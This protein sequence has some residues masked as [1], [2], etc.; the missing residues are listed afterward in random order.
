MRSPKVQKQPEAIKRSNHGVQQHISQ[1]H[2]FYAAASKALSALRS[3]HYRSCALQTQEKQALRPWYERLSKHCYA[4][5]TRWCLTPSTM[6][7][8][9]ILQAMGALDQLSFYPD[10]TLVTSLDVSAACLKAINASIACDPYIYQMAAADNYY[11]LDN[12]TI[13]QSIYNSR[14]GARLSQY[15]SSIATTCAPDP[16]PWD[17]VPATY[18]LNFV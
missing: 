9:F 16:M 10:N 11:T 12:A 3:S 8:I 13:Q 6:L 7:A 18:L 4:L 15:R 14:C 17:G 5:F 2:S 1:H